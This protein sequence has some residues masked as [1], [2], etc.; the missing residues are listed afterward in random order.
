MTLDDIFNRSTTEPNTGCWLWLGAAFPYGRIKRKGRTLGA[1]QASFRLATGLNP[2]VVMHVCDQPSCVNPTHLRA[3]THV[4]NVADRHRKGRTRNGT[5]QGVARPAAKLD[6]DGVRR[7]RAMAMQ[8]VSHRAIAATV[9]VH[10]SVVGNILRG[11]AWK[12]VTPAAYATGAAC[13][14]VECSVV[15]GDNPIDVLR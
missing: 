14:P 12:H 6:D 8:G 1:H 9:G 4:E 7:V 2:P 3:G 13:I 10:H 5:S 11:K 15:A